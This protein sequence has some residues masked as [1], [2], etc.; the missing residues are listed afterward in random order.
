MGK[1]QP[2]IV[3]P[4]LREYRTF[5]RIQEHADYDVPSRESEPIRLGRWFLLYHRLICFNPTTE[6]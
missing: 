4:K 6:R 5:V 3:I 1:Q 2:S